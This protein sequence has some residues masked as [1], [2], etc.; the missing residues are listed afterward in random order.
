MRILMDTHVLLWALGGSDRLSHAAAA[1]IQDADNDV[2]FSAATIWEVAIKGALGKA[3]FGVS[4]ATIHA[5]ALATGFVEVPVWSEAGLR[6][7]ALPLHH[8]DPFD[9][10]LV[11]QAE[12]ERATLYTADR[13]LLAYGPHVEL[14]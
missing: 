5:Q 9:R 4:P 13:Q 11:A 2:L 10:L 8:R 7:G 14:V 3:G 12:L 1:T 6:A